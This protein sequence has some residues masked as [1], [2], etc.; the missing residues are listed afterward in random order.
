MN[1][2]LCIVF[3]LTLSSICY[4]GAQDYEQD[5]R[6][7]QQAFQ[8]RLKTAQ[9]TLKQHL[10]NYPYSPYSDE[11]LLM[12][13]VLQTEKGKYKQATK[14]FNKV[15]AKNLSRE[16]QP[17]LYF[18]GGY[19]LIQQKQYDKALS[20]FLRLKNQKSI[21]APHAKYYAGYCYYCQ[22]DFPRAMAEFL[23]VEHLGVYKKIAPY[24]IVQIY[25]AQHEY[26]KVY[27]RAEELLKT[28]PDNANN[29]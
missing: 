2:R 15:E 4:L 10:I 20:L 26:N 14:V 27:S 29:D 24:Y 5:F 22:Q 1:K 9:N 17:M 25:Y 19:A 3:L 8:E 7:A 6:A 18:Y 28:Y 13:G 21:Y 11:I 23:S 12:E 16:T